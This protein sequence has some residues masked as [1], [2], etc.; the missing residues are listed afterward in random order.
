MSSVRRTESPQRPVDRGIG[1]ASRAVPHNFRA[2]VPYVS[3]AAH[4][5]RRAAARLARSITPPF[6]VPDL[7]H[8][9][10]SVSSHIALIV[11]PVA[12][13]GRAA[14]HAARAESA[15]RA[16]ASVRRYDTAGAGEERRCARAACEA[17]ASALAVVGG[18]GSV[19]HAARGLLDT[20]RPGSPPDVPL[21]VFAAGTGNDYVKSLGTPSHDARAMAERIARGHTRVVDVGLIDDVPF[22]NAAGLGFDVDVLE[23]LQRARRLSG[24]SAYVVTALRALLGYRGYQATLHGEHSKQVGPHLLTV[25]ANGGT[26]GGTFRIAPHASLDDGALALVNIHALPAVRRPG[27][28]FRATRGTHLT[29]RDVTHGRGT[30][31]RITSDAPLRFEADGELYTSR[32][33][34]IAVGVRARALRVIA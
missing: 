8:T 1:G 13:R 20:A 29:H 22:L 9:S 30:Q 11:N 12:G 23:R 28:F 10:P 17:G 32:H 33:P 6:V 34:E 3:D 18:D 2:P 14:A 5:R 7:R 4:R 21:A 27:V 26:F 15:L 19:H 24:T 16:V 31:W 25:F